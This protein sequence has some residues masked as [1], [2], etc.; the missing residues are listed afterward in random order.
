M[1]R[2]WQVEATSVACVLFSTA[3]L[4]G[5]TFVQWISALAVLFT[6]MHAQVSERMA[7]IQSLKVKPEVY[8]YR[9]S[10][11][12]FYA[13]EVLWCAVFSLTGAW[14]ALVGVGLFLLYPIWRR[15][16]RRYNPLWIPMDR[17]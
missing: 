13:K 1:I 7:E 9:W 11:R 6:F 15:W 5:G 4:T 14:P 12:Y 17:R 8:C 2:T 16:W 3:I 10:T